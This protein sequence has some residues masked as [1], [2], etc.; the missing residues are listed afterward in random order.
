MADRSERD[1]Y[2]EQVGE[3]FLV[4]WESY[5]GHAAVPWTELV[6]KKPREELTMRVW[7]KADNYYNYD[8]SD[9]VTLG[10]W[11]LADPERQVQIYGYAPRGSEVAK[12]LEKT[13]DGGEKALM[14]TFRYP[15]VARESR[16]VVLTAVVCEGW[17]KR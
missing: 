3:R 14:V 11:R 17:V 5:V 9:E 13:L 2:V 1:V 10:C 8:F 6:V 15:E 4:D 12:L 7:A 16:Q